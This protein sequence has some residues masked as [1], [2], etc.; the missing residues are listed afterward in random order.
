M[1]RNY[2]EYE[3]SYEEMMRS[4]H[5]DKS[6]FRKRTQEEFYRDNYRDRVEWYL[7]E[8]WGT[9]AFHNIFFADCDYENESEEITPEEERAEELHHCVYDII[10]ES[11]DKGMSINQ[12]AGKVYEYLSKENA[13]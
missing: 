12:T 10:E 11:Q 5:L 4:N 1:Y 8:E 6:K 7:M 2:E 13:I 3:R 9:E